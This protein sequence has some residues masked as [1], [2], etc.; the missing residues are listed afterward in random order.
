MQRRILLVDDEVGILRA[1]RRLFRKAGF[2]AVLAE[3]G[4]EALELIRQYEFPVIVSDFRM[5]EMDG[6]TLLKRVSEIDP[7]CV[8]IVLSG[9]AELKQ[10][11]NAFHSGGVHR[12][13]AKPWVD[14]ELIHEVSRAFDIA[15]VKRSHLDIDRDNLLDSSVIA[16]KRIFPGHL[17]AQIDTASKIGD[18]I[19][20]ALEFAPPQVVLSS[21]GYNAKQAFAALVTSLFQTMPAEVQYC[22]WSG[23]TL[24]LHL[25]K[26]S[27]VDAVE[28][29]FSDF[30]VD[31]ANHVEHAM[32]WTKLDQQDLSA[33]KCLENVLLELAQTFIDKDEFRSSDWLSLV[34]A[35]LNRR[36]DAA[37]D[38][39]N[40]ELV[41]QPIATENG[42]LKG[43][44]ALLR[45]PALS[46]E[47]DI[48]TLIRHASLLGHSD[49]LTDIQLALVFNQFASLDIKSDIKLVINF[50]LGQL[51]SPNLWALIDRYIDES[52]VEL[53]QI[54]IDVSESSL[55]SNNPDCLANLERFR[56]SGIQMTLDDQGSAHIYLNEGELPSVTAIKLDRGFI[57]QVA[58]HPNHQEMLA[59]LCERIVA[60][61]MKLS[62]EGVEDQAQF[63]FLVDRYQFFYQGYALS[64]G[65]N[66]TDIRSW[67]K[68]HLS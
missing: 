41:F 56:N 15:R 9:F 59:N 10:M 50:S 28:A 20:Y 19:L 39:R 64:K 26:S 55:R 45:C 30:L 3:S 48:A 65:L 68:T 57:Q 42:E 52:G 23:Y 2:D 13:V 62:F 25:T 37:L 35:D 22:H 12:F 51:C 4:S 40:F 8:G 24:I 33:N 43:L 49:Q 16:C 46:Q 1:L 6:G 32:R 17:V 58:T 47:I 53:S 5:P 66:L 7:S 63:D 11:L 36:I 60:T 34:D 29:A 14:A 67:L 21:S 27:A 61:G 44:E 38:S 54:S 31:N 18:S